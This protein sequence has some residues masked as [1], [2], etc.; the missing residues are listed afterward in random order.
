M[1]RKA[2]QIQNQ[3]YYQNFLNSFKSEQ[4]KRKYII[5][6]NYYLRYLGVNNPNSLISDKLLDSQP[7]IRQIEDQ[8]IDYINQLKK[9]KLS[10][11]A[12]NVCL[13]SIL[14]FYMVNRVNLNRRHIAQY[15]PQ[16]KK[17]RKDLAYTHEQIQRLID[18]TKNTERDR[19]MILLMASTGMR[20]GAL[21]TLT[22]GN[23]SKVYPE[24]YPR[25]NHI[26]KI[27]VYEGEREE[28]YT[29]TTFESAQA[30]DSYLDYRKRFGEVLTDKS[31]LFRNHL[32]SNLPSL[33][34]LINKPKFLSNKSLNSAMDRLLIRSG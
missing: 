10:Y 29:Y 20:I 11:S 12:I 26:Y 24:G 7:M 6:L 14:K 33:S 25:N 31:P 22:I 13:Y 15:K 9:S 30:L 21:C 27:I 1:V 18:S 19:A 32:N 28:Y 2:Q 17:T 5:E 8:I 34:K 23:I 3:N 4:T 16:Q